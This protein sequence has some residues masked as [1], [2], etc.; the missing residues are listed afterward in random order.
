M[1]WKENDLVVDRFGGGVEEE[2]AVE[3][4]PV[5]D[6]I[7]TVLPKKKRPT[8]SAKNPL[9]EAF[10]RWVLCIIYLTYLSI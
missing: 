7:K 4:Q 3:A 2:E 10:S 1:T 6:V 5:V 8:L 9:D